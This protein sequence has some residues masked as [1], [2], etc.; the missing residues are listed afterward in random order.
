M[1]PV[2][3]HR[4]PETQLKQRCQ[5]KTKVNTEKNETGILN[6][7][8]FIINFFTYLQVHLSAAIATYVNGVIM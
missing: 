3:F 1:I 4:D 7:H 6:F 8:N 5:L 2:G